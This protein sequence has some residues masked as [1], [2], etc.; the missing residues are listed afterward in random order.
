LGV[1]KSDESDI[2]WLEKSAYQGYSYG[3]YNLANCYLR[4]VR[5]LLAKYEVKAIDMLKD[6]ALQEQ[7]AGSHF[8]L[9]VS[10]FSG[11][12]V[13]KDRTVSLEHFIKS[14]EFG[15]VNARFN[16]GIFYELGLGGGDRFGGGNRELKIVNI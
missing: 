7:H 3:L 13:S 9:G 11:I 1:T 14:A 6:A 12:G 8:L 2:G 4:G 10:Y 15:D 16:V 5:G